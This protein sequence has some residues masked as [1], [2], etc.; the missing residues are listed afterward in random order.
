M[1]NLV[2]TLISEWNRN[3]S[4]VAADARKSAIPSMA[5]FF[6]SLLA[7]HP[8]IDGNGR[9]ARELLSLQARE[10]LGLEENLL[11]ERGSEYYSALRLADDQKFD[12]LERLISKA[13]AGTQ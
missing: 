4:D 3:Y 5:R 8:F 7:I 13:I 11:V 1:P 10:L 9:L 12:A 6:H 2:E